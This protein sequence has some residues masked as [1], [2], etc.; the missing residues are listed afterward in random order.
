MRMLG[1]PPGAQVFWLFV[2]A[3]PIASISWTITH[4]EVF[5]ELREYCSDRSKHCDRLVERKAFYVVTCAYC[6]SHW[7]ALAVVL[8][9]GYRLLLDD[10]R[11]VLIAI[12]ALVWVANIYMSVFARL[13]LGIKS[14]SKEIEMKEEA[15][16]GRSRRARTYRSPST[17]TN[18]A[19][20]SACRVIRPRKIEPLK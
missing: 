2:R 9:T 11:G 10:W 20:E 14:E 8:V 1:M 3:T 19:G 5:R 7:V 13:R 16:A 12:L 17:F 6:L 18:S 15:L 4:E